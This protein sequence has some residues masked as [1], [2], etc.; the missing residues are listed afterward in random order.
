MGWGPRGAPRA[1][2]W[3]TAQF[4]SQ[5]GSD[6]RRELLLTESTPNTVGEMSKVAP[7]LVL[8]ALALAAC[9]SVDHTETPAGVGAPAPG[10]EVGSGDEDVFALSAVGFSIRKPSSWHFISET[11]NWEVLDQVQLTDE[12]I[13]EH[14][15]ESS[16]DALVLI[17]KYQDP[18]DGADP[19]VK[20]TLN[21][22]DQ[23]DGMSPETVANLLSEGM[24]HLLEN[25]QISDAVTSTELDGH[26][27]A[28]YAGTYNDKDASGAPLSKF[29]EQWIVQHGDYVFT[30][31][32]S[33]PTEGEDASREEYQAIIESMVLSDGEP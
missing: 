23:L 25:F 5:H 18:G 15:R 19:A 11:E 9:K 13:A 27:A 3:C 29:S 17:A 28:H 10:A 30:L 4:G 16:A 20:V 32:G 24:A 26:P 31:A 1:I 14:V 2:T 12:Q 22:S 21:T 33:W 8:S 7:A 6:G